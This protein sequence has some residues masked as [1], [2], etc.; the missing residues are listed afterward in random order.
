MSE[1]NA[2][3]TE[4]LKSLKGAF[5]LQ[6]SRPKVTPFFSSPNAGEGQTVSDSTGVT[7]MGKTTSHGL[8]WKHNKDMSW[9]LGRNLRSEQTGRAGWPE[10]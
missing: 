6:Q 5:P 7:G 10:D 8:F 4:L 2:S 9:N 3:F 1:N